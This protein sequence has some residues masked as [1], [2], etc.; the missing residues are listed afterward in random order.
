MLIGGVTLE[1]GVEVVEDVDGE[2][3]ESSS[4]R[5]FFLV[6]RNLAYQAKVDFP[7]TVYLGPVAPHS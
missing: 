2:G 1:G 5:F 6:R 3:P 4:Q 7:Q